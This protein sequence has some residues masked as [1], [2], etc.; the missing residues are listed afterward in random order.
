LGKLSVFSFLLLAL[1][2]AACS[3]P[4]SPEAEPSSYT[5]TFK[6]NY[7]ARPGRAG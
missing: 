1:F 6:S 7:S 5:V 4:S 3:N 2:F